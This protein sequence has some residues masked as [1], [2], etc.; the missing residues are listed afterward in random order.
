MK[1]TVISMN[2][3]PFEKRMTKDDIM[4]LGNISNVKN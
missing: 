4:S 3:L 2:I 1:K